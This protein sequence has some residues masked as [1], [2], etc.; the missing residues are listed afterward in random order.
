MPATYQIARSSVAGNRPANG[1]LAA[2][3]PFV[4][5]A[6]QQLGVMNGSSVATD[7]IGVRFFSTAADYVE[8]DIVVFDGTLYK[9]LQAVTAGSF[10]AS[11]WIDIA[12]GTVTVSTTPPSEV[13][14]GS[15]W[16]DTSL[17]PPEL[18]VW[19]GSQFALVGA[20]YLPLSGGTVSGQITVTPATPTAAGHLSRKDYVD[21]QVLTRAPRV[22]IQDTAPGSPTTGD[23]W[24]EN[25]TLGRAFVW[26]GSTW[27]DFAPPAAVADDLVEKAGDTMTGDLTVD[28]ADIILQSSGAGGESLE[29]NTLGQA[30]DNRRFEIRTFGENLRVASL[31]DSGTTQF[32]FLFRRDGTLGSTN[33][34]PTRTSGDGRWLQLAG[35]TMTGDL[36]MDAADITLDDP[37]NGLQIAASGTPVVELGWNGTLDQLVLRGS[38]GAGG[39]NSGRALRFDQ[40]GGN[41]YIDGAVFT[42]D[43]LLLNRG[44]GDA[45]WLQLSGGTMTGELVMDANLRLSAGFLDIDTTASSFSDPGIY[46]NAPGLGLHATGD[47]VWI[48]DAAGDSWA[49]LQDTGTALDNPVSV[50]TREKGDAR[51]L[52]LSG[53]TVTGDVVFNGTIDIG[54]GINIGSSSVDGVE[55]FNN[56][57]TT[58]Q[59]TG[60]TGNNVATLGLYQGTT[61]TWRVQV[62]GDV[63]NLNNSYGAIS[64]A[65]LKTLL[66]DPNLEAQ[67]ADIAA[68]QVRK[69]YLNSDADQ[70][71]QI[72]LVAQEVREV[73]PGLVT[74]TEDGL[75]AVKYSVAYMKLLAAFQHAQS[76]ISDLSSRVSALE[77]V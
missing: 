53:G 3:T 26:N 5:F 42:A 44:E 25:N 38:D 37:P 50:V 12:G 51:Y 31:T 40:G 6:D 43:G 23:L 36:T 8:G 59:R 41:W 9:A 19:D 27:I 71:P 61:N 20:A 72:G 70:R 15:L 57:A 69:F 13:I 56:S 49:R 66:D 46:W 52:T 77:G 48:V 39:F 29:W 4:N 28:D 47:G 62:D 33:A 16:F 7:L 24:F 17:S 54:G 30:V 14:E 22:A 74:E 60:G 55:I 67:Y 1:S 11:E 34:V 35:G 65:T 58:W 63:Q 32:D 68:L 75:L 45:R 10:T 21:T 73:S 76:I 18:K 2:G 64:D